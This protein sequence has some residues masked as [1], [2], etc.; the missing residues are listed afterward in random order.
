MKAKVNRSSGFRVWTKALDAHE[1]NDIRFMQQALDLAAQGRGYVEPNPLVG[2]VIVAE[3]EAVGKG[4]HKAY[5]GPHAEVDALRDAGERA[6]G[7]TMY[8]TLEPCCHQG[9]T[10]PC[11]DAVIDAGLSRV[12]VARRD[13]FP[14]V[15]GG[16]I[17]RLQQAGIQVD[18]GVLGDA[19]Q[20]MN[21]PYLH[22]VQTGQPWIIA[23]WAMTL[24]GKIASRSGHSQWISGE[25]SRDVVHQLRGRVDAI[26]VGSRT[27]AVDNPR[28]TA[29][30]EK[31]R[32]ALR[33]V[34]DSEANL[35]VTS[36][37]VQT[38]GEEPVLVAVS[39]QADAE[40]CRALEQAG[41]EVFCCTATTHGERLQELLKE[42]GNRRLTN[43]LV[44][45]G[46]GLLGALFD[47][48]QINEVH[49]FIAPKLIGGQQSPTP[50]D[51]EGQQQIPQLASL[52][53]F[54]WQQLGDD[55][56]LHGLV[57]RDIE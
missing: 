50:L 30:G 11:A 45:G 39:E 48:E 12:V 52:G 23:K 55:L 16:G 27:A 51:G 9:K 1:T 6:R 33:I 47:I 17:E 29:R 22:L 24:D 56:Y 57:R 28:L 21:L 40:R 3:G 31:R 38:A 36:Q 37:L 14:Q 5:G 49:A 35:P 53:S 20:E 46:G 32:T 18:V 10:P 54:Q 34:I 41:C 25:A 7:A 2:C 43:V 13:P 26:M 8:V 42:L 44:E 4:W 15:A 19:A